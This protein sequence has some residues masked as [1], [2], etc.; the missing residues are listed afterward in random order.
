MRDLYNENYSSLKKVITE[1][2]R[3]WKDIPCSWICRINNMKMDILPKA[4]Y[5]F[6]AIHVK[7]PITFLTDVEK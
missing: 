5:T 1:K 3:R 7:I 4:S 6:N 2:I